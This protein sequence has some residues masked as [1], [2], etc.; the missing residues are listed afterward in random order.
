MVISPTE[1][2]LKASW[3]C[4]TRPTLPSGLTSSSFS[5]CLTGR[6][7]RDSTKHSDNSTRLAKKLQFV[8][9]LDVSKTNGIGEGTTGWFRS[10]DEDHLG[11]TIHP[12]G[13]KVN[14]DIDV[15]GDADGNMIVTYT[16]YSGYNVTAEAGTGGVHFLT[17]LAAEDGHE[18]WK[19]E[20][21]K[22]LSE[23]EPI[24]D[25]SIFCGV[26]MTEADSA[27][28]FGNS[29]VVPVIPDSDKSPDS[30]GKL[31]ATKAVVVKFNPDGIAQWAS[32]T[33]DAN[34]ER[35]SVSA[36]GTLLAI[37]GTPLSGR[38]DFLSRIDTSPGNEG[39]VLWTDMSSGG[40]THG[41]RGVEV[42]GTEVIG[43]GQITSTMTLTDS[44]GS[45]T[46][47]SSRG[48]YE[49]FVAAFDAADGTGK[50][51][52]DGGSDGLDYFFAFASDSSTGD[53]YVG[54]ASYDTPQYFQW[55][56][57]KRK[58]AMYRYKPS[59]DIPGYVGTHRRRS[60]PRSRRQSRSRL[61]SIPVAPEPPSSRPAIA[62]LT[63]TATPRAT[64]RRTPGPTACTVAPPPKLAAAPTR[65]PRQ[66]GAGPTRPP[67]ALSTASASVRARTSKW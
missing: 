52:M 17:K 33:H 27:L 16:G 59:A 24:T 18:L 56:D 43:F 61:A 45:K 62:T 26:T 30:T 50:W 54:G 32:T 63:A 44:T 48:S 29:V 38:V 55:G 36:D 5:P 53:I 25:G 15:H 14:S 31:V 34:F 6:A 19:M 21:A 37:A 40:G 1:S 4:W 67:I 46:T 42:V 60:S 22:P 57:V 13:T 47:L 28:D 23:C 9:K 39:A 64:S 51:A 11:N 20:F 12:G 49:V 3:R 41:F 8:V 7:V 10:L 65:P 58:N 35:L 2:K 66:R